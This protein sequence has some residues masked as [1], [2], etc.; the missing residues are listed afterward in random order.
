V[1]AVTNVLCKSPVAGLEIQVARIVDVIVI[2]LNQ[3]NRFQHVEVTVKEPACVDPL[4][5]AIEPASIAPVL[6]SGGTGVVSR[7]GSKNENTSS[8]PKLT[9]NEPPIIA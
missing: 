9:E 1:I 3:L 5:T 8:I 7:R 6:H 4:G 2:S